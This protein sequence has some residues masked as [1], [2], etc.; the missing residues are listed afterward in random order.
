[1]CSNCRLKC[2][3]LIAILIGQLCQKPSCA[4]VSTSRSAR[5][6]GSDSMECEAYFTRYGI[7]CLSWAQLGSVGLSWAQLGG[8]LLGSVVALL[9][10][11]GG[12]RG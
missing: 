6:T 12:G 5:G 1:M 4:S 7:S 10:S 11:F 3:V 8:V 9:G 2:V